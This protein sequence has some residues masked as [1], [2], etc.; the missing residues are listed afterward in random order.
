MLHACEIARTLGIRRVVVPAYPGLL[1]AYGCL[2][3]NL[4]KDAIVTTRGRLEDIDLQTV[5]RELHGVADELV[6][7]LRNMEDAPVT[8]RALYECQFERQTHTLYVEAALDAGF[9][10]IAAAFLCQ[11]RQH[12]GELLPRSAIELRSVRLGAP[13][14]GRAGR[15]AISSSATSCGRGVEHWR[16]ELQIGARITG[17]TSVSGPD[18]TLYLPAGSTA[19]VVDGG[20]IVVEVSDVE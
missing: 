15:S 8:V 3:A 17:P 11:Y 2:V 13:A 6:A 14:V 19:E 4:A 10:E 9:V 16:P 12:Y 1:S 5:Q 20:N 18:A 7:A